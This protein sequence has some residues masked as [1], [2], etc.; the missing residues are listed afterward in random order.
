MKN[1]ILGFVLAL[2]LLVGIKVSA[3]VISNSIPWYITDTLK[4]GIGYKY[5]K[6]YD[7]NTGVAC[8]AFQIGGSGGISCVKIN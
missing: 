2:V 1:I 8:Y 3:K 6:T 4:S 7:E 5:E